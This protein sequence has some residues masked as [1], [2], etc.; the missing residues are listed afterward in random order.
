MFHLWP[1]GTSLNWILN[2]LCTTP[3]V[4]TAYFTNKETGCQFYPKVLSSISSIQHNQRCAGHCHIKWESKAAE[5][6]AGIFMVIHTLHFLTVLCSLPRTLQCLFC[7]V[8]VNWLKQKRT[9][10]IKI[11]WFL[12]NCNTVSHCGCIIYAQYYF[13]KARHVQIQ[14]HIYSYAFKHE[15]F[16]SSSCIPPYTTWN[17][18]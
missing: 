10:C 18:P 17:I 8:S 15:V 5:N 7:L 9:S 1:V 16:Y 3:L 12:Y 6:S 11:Q 4:F 2:L 13:L 14:R